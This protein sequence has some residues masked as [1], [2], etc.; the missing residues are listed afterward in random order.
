M[1]SPREFL[2]RHATGVSVPLALLVGLAAMLAALNLFGGSLGLL[3]A[4]GDI[5]SVNGASCV[6][7]AVCALIAFLACRQALLNSFSPA[8]LRLLVVLYLA[9]LVWVTLF[10]SVGVRGVN[11]DLGDIVSQIRQEPESLLVNLLMYVPLGAIVRGRSLSLPKALAVGLGL[12]LVFEVAQYAFALGIFDVVD[13]TANL[14][15]TLTGYLVLDALADCGLGLRRTEG[16]RL[17]VVLSPR[18][19]RHAAK[20]PSPT[21]RVVGVCGVC[22]L[23]LL[24]FLAVRALMWEPTTVQVESFSPCATLAALPRRGATAPSE[25]DLSELPGAVA[26]GGLVTLGCRVLG[27][28]TWES[29]DGTRCQGLDILVEEPLGN[30]MTVSHVLPAVLTERSSIRVAGREA[31]LDEASNLLLQSAWWAAEI[32]LEPQDGWL[33]VE[34]ADLT[35]DLTLSDS[36]G[37]ATASFPWDSYDRL[38]ASDGAAVMRRMAEGDV[39]EIPGYVTSMSSV[40]GEPTTMTLCETTRLLGAPAIDAYGVRVDSGVSLSAD[41]AGSADDLRSFRLRLADG[42]LELAS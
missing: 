15:G 9:A 12:S 7:G 28:V 16:D 5:E 10:K 34:R 11:F 19:P 41:D 32:A 6:F 30:G 8:F 33:R 36:T 26:D 35:E 40:E 18:T 42:V 20:S 24:A 37:T 31:S 22:A 3:L 29:D 38:E 39:V 21:R 1:G 17:R 2:R 14:L 4:G 25:D 13:V 27:S 23:G